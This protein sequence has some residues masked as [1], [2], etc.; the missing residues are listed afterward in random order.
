MSTCE[1]VD[2]LPS[3]LSIVANRLR[4]E[5]RIEFEAMGLVPRHA[6]Y[7]LWKNSSYRRTAFVDGE[8]AAVWGCAGMVLST[9][10]NAWFSTTPVIERVPMT[11]VKQARRGLAE[12]M[13]S[14]STLISACGDSFERSIRLWTMLGFKLGDTMSAPNGVVFRHLIMER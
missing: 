9:V 6:L 10:G 1:V 11:F 5:E 8:I 7:N 12:M 14:K 4:I 2:C 13:Q 3:H